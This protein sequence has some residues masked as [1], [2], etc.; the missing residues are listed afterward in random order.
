[1]H[2]GSFVRRIAIGAGLA[3]IVSAWLKHLAAAAA[4]GC[5]GGML[6]ARRP[7]GQDIRN[8]PRR[9]LSAAPRSTHVGRRSS[10]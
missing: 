8:I 1:M 7:D 3:A 2:P 9:H 10:P 5:I 6:H 4:V